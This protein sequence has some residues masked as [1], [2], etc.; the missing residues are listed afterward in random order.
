MNKRT[1]LSYLAVISAFLLLLSCNDNETVGQEQQPIAGVDG[2]TGRLG[3]TNRQA[4][5]VMP[6]SDFS[7]A[8]FREASSRSGGRSTLLSPLSAAFALGMI[9]EGATAE[10]QQEI[11]DAMGIGNDG[12]RSV[13]DLL[14]RIAA[15][16]AIVDSTVSV[17]FANNVTVSDSFT[18]SVAYVKAVQEGY[19]ASVFS[20]DFS[21]PGTLA[22]INAWCREQSRGLIPAIA[23]ELDPSTVMCILNVIYFKGL[24][25]E[26]FDK[27]HSS[28]GGFYDGMKWKEILTMR[29]TAKAEYCKQKGLKALRLPLG[30]GHFSV[31]F[32]LPDAKDGLSQLVGLVSAEKLKSL[33]FESREVKMS[34]PVF[35][36]EAS[37]DLK[38]LL[39]AIGIRSIF[40]PLHSG[41]DGIADN[42]TASLFV[43]QMKQNTRLGMDEQGT[44][45]A[46]VTEAETGITSDREGQSAPAASFIA[47][48]PFIYTVSEQESGVI[49]FIGQF[50]GN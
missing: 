35:S 24:W 47:D 16:S 32:L 6:L 13:S 37:S 22:H 14:I 19:R 10:T 38:P 40:D 18:P 45:G 43:S 20:M 41:L 26:P 21:Q 49:Y 34:L 7:L 31:T 15:N 8:L 1:V 46:A 2:Q 27:A 5:L 50:C 39:E 4:A 23:D 44:E 28:G 33:A 11:I 17:A 12:F 36:T 3:L 29:R 42:A 30:S 48:H 25:Q 9:G